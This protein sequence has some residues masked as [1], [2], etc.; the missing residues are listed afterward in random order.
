MK[1]SELI[2]AVAAKAEVTKGDAEDVLDAFTQVARDA[3]AEG[4]KV[5]L[6]DFGTFATKDRAART[7]RNPQ[8]GQPVQIPAKTVAQ[9]K[10]AKSLADHLA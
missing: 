8:T 4:K 1:K 3:L 7:G 5:P 6:T 2:A 9:F 10:P